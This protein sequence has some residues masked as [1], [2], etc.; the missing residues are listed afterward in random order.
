ME[1]TSKSTKA[2][3]LGSGHSFVRVAVLDVRHLRHKC[4]CVCVCV[5]VSVHVNVLSKEH[6]G[7]LT[8]TVRDLTQRFSAPNSPATQG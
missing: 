4:V 3:R 1:G 6:D 8:L 5:C 2:S 7:P